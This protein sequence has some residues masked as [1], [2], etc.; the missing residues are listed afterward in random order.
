[1]NDEWMLGRNKRGCEGIFPLSYIEIKVPLENVN[2]TPKV[3]Q[4]LIKALYD[5]NAETS[6]DLTIKV[7]RFESLIINLILIVFIFLRKMT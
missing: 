7:N 4:H 3:T 2:S 5:F 6:D 1:M